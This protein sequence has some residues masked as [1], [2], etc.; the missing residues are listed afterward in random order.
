MSEKEVVV[1]G[2]GMHKF[3]RFPDK[4][5]GDLAQEAGL[6]ALK[7]AGMSP[8]D[9]Q[10]GFC[11][12]VYQPMMTGI[13]AFS[14]LGITGIPVTNV[15]VACASASRSVLLGASTILA[16]LCDTCMVIG[17]EKM[18]RG[19]IPLTGTDWPSVAHEARIGVITTPLFYSMKATRHML[20]YGTKPEHFA[21]ASVIAH[22]NGVLN[23]Y[24]Q[25]QREMTLEEIMNSRMICYP[26]T[27][28]QCCS[29]SDGA[30]AVVMCS[31]E[32]ARQYG[33][34]PIF[35][36]GWSAGSPVYIPGEWNHKFEDLSVE[37]VAP[38]AYEMAGIGPGDIDVA[39]V[40]DAFSPG[41]IFK[42]EELGLCPIGEGGPFVWE[43]NTE[44]NGKIP[45]N[46][47]GG[48]IGRGHPVGATGAAMIYELVQQLRG[49]AGP[50]QVMGAKTALLQNSGGGGG[51]VM[52]FKT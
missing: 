47:D 39:Q 15:E 51:N 3:G 24:A 10:M 28:Y 17:L 37:L 45:V 36:V 9:V 6:M 35:L 27:L 32:K 16:G 30:S 2:V 40:H 11:A 33:T 26:I 49:E 22:R 43:G 34:K 44:T 1:L 5:L 14:S 48:L 19:L 8:R 18:G 29:T 4:S 20:E 41:L 23:P 31:K 50:R 46:T 13:Q 7:D 52:I 21:Y 25:Y 38:K 12:H 42:I